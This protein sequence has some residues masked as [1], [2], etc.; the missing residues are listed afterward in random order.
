LGV[1]PPEIVK[2]QNDE[3][4]PSDDISR[5]ILAVIMFHK[6]GFF[7]LEAWSFS[8][9]L[10][11]CKQ[12]STFFDDCSEA[13]ISGL[14]SLCELN[15]T[16]EISTLREYIH[17]VLL[18]RTGLAPMN[19][20]APL[21]LGR[22]IDV[23]QAIQIAAEHG[24]PQLHGLLHYYVLQQALSSAFQEN[25]SFEYAK[26][27]PAGLATEFHKSKFQRGF[28]SL[29]AVYEELNR[30][31]LGQDLESYC[32]CGGNSC[33]Q[34][35]RMTLDSVER[36]CRRQYR[37]LDVL[38]WLSVGAMKVRDTLSRADGW[39]QV[40]RKCE[41]RLIAVITHREENIKSRLEKVFSVSKT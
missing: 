23:V 10:K 16:P 26:F 11:H 40:S 25:K 2:L 14:L 31:L 5:L 19:S 33:K 41:D 38:G 27:L 39:M 32:I 22:K 15:V 7:S 24:L 21:A 30:Q 20:A 6:Y 3:E 35:A 12:E 36:R 29:L 9:V 13:D 8:I 4:L 1:R 18:L 34:G 37:F 17:Q 28:M